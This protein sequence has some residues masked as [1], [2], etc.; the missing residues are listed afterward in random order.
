MEF[1]LSEFG[2]SMS[3]STVCRLLKNLNQTHKRVKRTYL[4]RDDELR[5]HFRAKMCGYKANQLVFVDESAADERTKNRKWGWSLKGL[6]CK[7]RQSGKRSTRWSILPAMGINGYIDYEIIQGGFNADKFNFFVRLLLRKMNPF[8]G[9]RS[10]LVLDNVGTHLSEDLAAMCEEAGVHLEYLPPYLPDYNPIEESF[11]ALKAWMRRNREL[12]SA[13]EP[14]FEGYMHLAVQ[15]AC[16]R[17]AVRGFFR[18]ASI[19][20]NEEDEDVD[21][22]EL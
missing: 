17:K 11:S 20:V 3:V 13:F 12:V 16:N 22:T 18:W 8:P 10:V 14:F 19:D 7:V 2:I 5:A 21:Y 6:P 9:P 15:M 4:N 1:L